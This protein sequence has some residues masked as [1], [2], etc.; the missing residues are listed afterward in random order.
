MDRRTY[1][2]R[3]S[4]V[5]VHGHL[6]GNASRI[7]LFCNDLNFLLVDKL[8]ELL[9]LDL[10]IDSSPYGDVIT[11]SPAGHEERDQVASSSRDDFTVPPFGGY[12][13]I[14]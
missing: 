4:T 9:T 3:P 10:A 12:V 14:A 11:A 7:K 8:S 13:L 1:F 2:F 5:Q 6:T